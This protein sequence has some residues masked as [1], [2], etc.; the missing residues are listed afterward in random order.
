MSIIYHVV[1]VIGFDSA[2]W[3]K[4]SIKIRKIKY[5]AIQ[6][7]CEIHTNFKMKKS[8]III[9]KGAN[10]PRNLVTRFLILCEICG[11]NYIVHHCTCC[12]CARK[13]V[14]DKIYYLR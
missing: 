10:I 12:V 9:P 2:K 8:S 3:K 4:Y 7:L 13:R 5:L 11:H 6:I 14:N 1:R